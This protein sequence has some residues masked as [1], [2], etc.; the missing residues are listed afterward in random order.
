MGHLGQIIVLLKF[1]ILSSAEFSTFT[2]DDSSPCVLKLFQNLSRT[3]MAKL[4]RE[5]QLRVKSHKM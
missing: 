4:R 3:K 2:V 1:V 5:A